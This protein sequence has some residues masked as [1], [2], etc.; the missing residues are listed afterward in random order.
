MV[1]LS[2]HNRPTSREETPGMQDKLLELLILATG[3]PIKGLLFLTH[4]GLE[5]QEIL[6]VSWSTRSEGKVI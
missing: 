5:G 4:K 1:G 2:G 3:N 6:R